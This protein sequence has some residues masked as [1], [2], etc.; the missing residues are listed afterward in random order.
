MTALLVVLAVLGM[1]ASARALLL[2][3]P[4]EAPRSRAVDPDLLPPARRID[5]LS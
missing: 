1:A 4:R 5:R 3:P 2:D